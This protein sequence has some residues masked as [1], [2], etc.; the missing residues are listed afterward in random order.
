MQAEP[1][2]N[3]V[4]AFYNDMGM[5]GVPMGWAKDVPD[6]GVFKCLYVT[7]P[8]WADLTL[9]CKLAGRLMMPGRGRWRA[10]PEEMRIPEEKDGPA[11]EEER[12][13]FELSADGQLVPRG[14]HR[15]ELAVKIR[16]RHRAHHKQLHRQLFEREAPLSRGEARAAAEVAKAAEAAVKAEQAHREAQKFW[17]NG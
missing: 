8:G 4:D 5:S 2:E 9:R 7:R 1:G 3:V 6:L 17:E 15:R 11:A 16:R 13:A 12:A 14:W 10:V